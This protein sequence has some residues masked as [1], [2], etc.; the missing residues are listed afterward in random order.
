MVGSSGTGA[1]I[2]LLTFLLDLD[3]LKLLFSKLFQLGSLNTIVVS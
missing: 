2:R 1:H 3:L